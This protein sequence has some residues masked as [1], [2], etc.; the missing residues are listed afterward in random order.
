MAFLF[1]EL[2]Y[3]LVDS[4]FGNNGLLV[5]LGYCRAGFGPCRG[6]NGGCGQPGYEIEVRS[7]GDLYL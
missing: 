7:F 1:V 4:R 5:Y 2:L 6:K 3:L